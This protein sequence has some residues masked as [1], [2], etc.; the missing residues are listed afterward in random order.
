[1]RTFIRRNRYAIAACA[2]ALAGAAVLGTFGISQAIAAEGADASTAEDAVEQR[3]EGD[4]TILVADAVPAEAHR[5]EDVDVAAT[6]EPASVD[7]AAE[8][9]SAESGAAE[10]DIAFS[11]N[12]GTEEAYSGELDADDYIDGE[13]SE[14]SEYIDVD[15]V[16]SAFNASVLVEDEPAGAEERPASA[17]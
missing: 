7:A 2:L 14:S 5:S 1:M 12:P 10:E 11:E 13:A 17:I 3:W 9:A 15:E 4:E 16:E 8:E 6:E